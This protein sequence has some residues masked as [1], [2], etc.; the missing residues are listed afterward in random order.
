MYPGVHAVTRPAHPALV[1][2][3]SGAAISYAELNRRSIRL[4]RVFDALGLSSAAVVAV[5]CEN[6]L[7]WAEMI[8]AAA[9][10]GRCLAPAN[11]HLGPRELSDVLR[12]SGAEL[13]LAGPASHAALRAVDD[14]PPT[15]AIDGDGTLPDYKSAIAAM[16]DGPLA[17]ERLGGRMMFSSGTT[18]TP[19]GILHP[20][21]DIHPADAPPHLGRYTELFV[22]GGDMVYLS[23]APTY[24]TAPFR[25]VLAVTQ[26]GGT[27]VCLE[28]FDPQ[29]VLAAIE[30]YR[31][32][33]AQFVPTMLLRLLRL[34]D[35][36]KRRYD[37]SSLRV[38]ITG[39][40][41]CPHE[42]KMRLMDWW[43]PVVH[44]LYGASESYGNCHIGPDEVAAH[45]GS[46]G[47]ALTGTIHI[48]DPDG[49][50]LP[51]GRIGT[52]WFEGAG[53]FEYR[54]DE[55]KTQESM[56][57]R[58]WRTVG[59]MGYLDE[60]GYLY[61]TGRRDQLIICGGVNIHPQEAED[62]LLVHPAVEDVAVIGIPDEEYGQIPHA[63]VVPACDAAPGPELGT[64]LIAYCRARLAHY[65][66]PRSVEFVSELP[67]GENGKLYKR[68]LTPGT[69]TGG[70]RQQLVS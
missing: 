44:E 5:A 7:E 12:A 29:L 51:P 68:K 18:G 43:G 52:V 39:G 57:P 16:P 41:P 1:M 67:R 32:T 40:A 54:G 17:G 26:L 45:P 49:T 61:L 6:R 46:V 50:E 20:G 42:V 31:V 37:L 3:G 36:V 23:P 22:F 30:R 21:S 53:S 62:V 33:H 66:C 4:A 10:S 2:A 9:R 69:S 25:F 19:K 58:G 48:T 59:D 55:R 28:K 64:R 8:W 65:K 38:A 27:V 70:E 14:L 15:L 13:L 24:H 63:L 56:H 34:P 11:W 60:D 35:D 47:R